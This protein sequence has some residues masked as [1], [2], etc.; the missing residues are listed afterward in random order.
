MQIGGLILRGKD[1][2]IVRDGRTLRGMIRQGHIQEPKHG[3][4]PQVDGELGEFTY[5]GNRYKL[6]YFDG[7]IYPFVVKL[8]PNK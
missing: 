5:R 4:L 1:D 8:T 2:V 3:A 6:K 7:S